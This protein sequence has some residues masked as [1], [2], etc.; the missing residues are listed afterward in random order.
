M[1]FLPSWG[2]I[3]AFPVIPSNMRSG[4]EPAIPAP[5]KPWSKIIDL[6]TSL[7]FLAIPLVLN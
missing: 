3:F 4:R 6:Q 1:T 7:A 2:I 5:F